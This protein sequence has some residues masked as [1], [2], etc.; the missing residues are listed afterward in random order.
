MGDNC[1]RGLGQRAVWGF[2]VHEVLMLPSR[3]RWVTVETFHGLSLF[4]IHI[5][6]ELGNSFL[7]L[8]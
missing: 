7:F 6:K 3:A 8:T 5:I 2:G 1:A 4:M